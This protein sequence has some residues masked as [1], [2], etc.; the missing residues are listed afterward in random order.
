M[1]L[2]GKGFPAIWRFAVLLG[3]ISFMSRFCSCNISRC[4]TDLKKKVRG[5]KLGKFGIVYFFIP[6]ENTLLLLIIQTITEI[7]NTYFFIVTD[8]SF[9]EKNFIIFLY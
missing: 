2:F 4:L 7:L 9:T 1:L 6:S 8:W 3:L 5:L